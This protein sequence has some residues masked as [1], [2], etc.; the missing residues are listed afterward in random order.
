MAPPPVAH[1]SLV[2]FQKSTGGPVTSMRPLANQT[3]VWGPPFVGELGW[4]SMYV[5]VLDEQF[6]CDLA[7]LPH[8]F[9]FVDLLEGSKTIVALRITNVPLNPL[10]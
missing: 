8:M 1:H 3:S 10:G 7:L 5:A 6:N 2:L 4:V 9:Q